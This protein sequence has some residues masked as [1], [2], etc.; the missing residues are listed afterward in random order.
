[1]ANNKQGHICAGIMPPNARY[2]IADNEFPTYSSKHKKSIHSLIYNAAIDF[3]LAFQ[4]VCPASRIPALLGCT[5][6][7]SHLLMHAAIINYSQ[8]KLY[9]INAKMLLGNRKEPAHAA[10]MPCG[11]L[12]HFSANTKCT[13]PARSLAYH[14]N[15]IESVHPIVYQQA[16]AAA[17]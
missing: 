15:S 16:I 1:M 9:I 12:M 13:I 14:T 2:D 7:T 8:V 6:T 3:P 11:R 5:Q 4:H 10:G 17:C